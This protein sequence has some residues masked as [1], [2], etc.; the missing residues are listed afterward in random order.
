ML[1]ETFLVRDA[2]K[3]GRSMG[4]KQTKIIKSS[5]RVATTCCRCIATKQIALDGKRLCI[6]RITALSSVNEAYNMMEMCNQS[7]YSIYGQ[8][9]LE[10]NCFDCN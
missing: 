3:P 1:E 5:V 2:T 4:R 7:I 8:K 9:A 6:L 10:T